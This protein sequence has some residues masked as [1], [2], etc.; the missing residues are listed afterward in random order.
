MDHLRGWGVVV[1]L[2]VLSACGG[3]GGGDEVATV[4]GQVNWTNNNNGSTVI[5]GNGA[6]FYFSAGNGCMYST[7]NSVGPAGFCLTNTSSSTGPTNCSN[8]SSNTSCDASSFRVF[9][10]APLSGGGCIAVLG[11]A[12]PQTYL[13]PT[14]ATHATYSQTQPLNVT[15]TGGGFQIQTYKTYG[16]TSSNA[17]APTAYMAYWNAQIPA[18][19]GSH[20]RAGTYTLQVNATCSSGPISN[21]AFIYTTT[22]TVDSH[23]AIVDNGTRR[24]WGTLGAS[25]DSGSFTGT[26]SGGGTPERFSIYT[27]TNGGIGGS[28]GWTFQ[29][30]YN[31]AAV[32]FNCGTFAGT[33]T[34][35]RN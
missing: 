3:G 29:G 1:G 25:G 26:P 7:I 11:A 30:T 4:P 2:C 14:G 5:D 6:T 21:N 27:I 24:I 31:P 10:T 16:A 12:V 22:I 18:C 17:G 28:G 13:G 8:P 23:G 33:F 35:T 19:G 32:P 20:A 34:A 9:L 15:S